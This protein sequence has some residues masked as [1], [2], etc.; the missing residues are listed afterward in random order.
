MGNDGKHQGKTQLESDWKGM[1]ARC[2]NLPHTTQWL[3]FF[4]AERSSEETPFLENSQVSEVKLGSGR[5][6]ANLAILFSCSNNYHGSLCLLGHTSSHAG[7]IC[8]FSQGTSGNVCGCFLV[9]TT[10]MLLGIKWVET[11]DAAK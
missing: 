3:L 4:S 1:W 2:V 7:M 6:L 9:V 11:K 10:Q 8:P 5:Q